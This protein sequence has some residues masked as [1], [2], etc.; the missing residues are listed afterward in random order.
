MRD[1]P[2]PIAELNPSLPAPLDWIVKRCLAKDPENRYDSTRDLER[3]LKS[4]AEGTQSGV[5]VATQDNQAI[6]SVAVLPLVNSSG[7]PE[8]EYFADGMTEALIFDL[9]RLRA[10]KIISRT[11]AMRYKG[12]DKS[13]PQIAKELSVDAVVEGS[14]LRVG[15]RV[16]VR[17]QLIHAASDTHLWA[18]SYE[19]EFEDLLDLQSDIAQAIAGE[20]QVAVA[21]EESGRMARP[22][23]VNAEAYEAYLKGRFYFYK[24]S[25]EDF[26]FAMEY[27]QRA[28]EKDP[29]YALAYVGIAE[30]WIGRAESGFVPVC[31]AFPRIKAAT[32]K[33][34]DLDD[35]L[36]K[37]HNSLASLRF[38]YE[39]NWAGAE[40][41]FRRAIELNPNDADVRFFY[42]DFLMSMRR[43]EEATVEVGRALELD[44]LNSFFHC[45]LGWHLL[46]LHRSDDAVA[47]LRKTAKMEPN[48]TSVRMGLWGAFYQKRMY[49]EALAEAA[50]FFD[51]LDDVDV[52]EALERGSAEAGYQ[53]AMKLAA[54]VLEERS[55]QTHVPGVRIGRLFAHAGENDCALDWLEKAYGEREGP[56]VHLNV[57][58]DWDDL[59]GDLRFQELLRRMKFPE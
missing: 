10:L 32:L 33:A 38:G 25:R 16:R 9:A 20:I 24:F 42:S 36:A 29:N 2:E 54:A 48:M 4:L 17:A 23:P 57:A 44:P 6:E 59:R 27:F 8:Q 52:V 18:E 31:E 26:D 51:L 46:Y 55:K 47:Q 53:G 28:L 22:D 19:R 58:W 43:F 40:T 1:K 15:Q 11:S 3:E 41:E 14:V 50:K 30:T 12:T 37:A 35:S 49:E 5:S 13:L 21:P 39:W 45:F 34:L 7:D 56:L